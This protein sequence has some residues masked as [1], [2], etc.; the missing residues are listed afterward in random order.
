MDITKIESNVIYALL[1]DLRKVQHRLYCQSIETAAN[2][3]ADENLVPNNLS[4]FMVAKPF[5]V[6]YP[7]PQYRM[8]RNKAYTPKYIETDKGGLIKFVIFIKTIYL[9]MPLIIG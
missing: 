4:Y 6:V 5:S 9:S 3:A 7:A 8:Y 2:L 1:V